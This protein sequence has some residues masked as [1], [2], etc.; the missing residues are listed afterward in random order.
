[1]PTVIVRGLFTPL[2]TTL[3]LTGFTVKRQFTTK[4]FL[5]FCLSFHHFSDTPLHRFAFV[6]ASDYLLT[7]KTNRT[8]LSYDISAALNFCY[9]IN[10]E[11]TL[12]CATFLP[13]RKFLY[14]P[15]Y[16]K[17]VF[18]C[19]IFAPLFIEN[20]PFKTIRVFF[21]KVSFYNLYTYIFTPISGTKFAI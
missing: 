18:Q 6:M 17:W 9:F 21:T 5:S 8:N 20:F 10:Y 3:L 14:F 7:N 1:M 2:E 13:H 11:N 15:N 19:G 12:K 4:H 16:K